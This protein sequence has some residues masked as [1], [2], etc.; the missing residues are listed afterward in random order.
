MDKLIRCNLCESK[1]YEFVYHFNK[2]IIP[3]NKEKDIYKIT[4]HSR[5]NIKNKIFRCL[6]CGLVFIHPTDE[7]CLYKKYREAQ[8]NEYLFE[9]ESKRLSARTV[10]KRIEKFVEIGKLLDIGC[11]AGFLLSEAKRRGWD[12]CGVEPSEWMVKF[13]K[14]RLHI[15]ILQGAFE[16]K[17]SPPDNFD[18]IVMLDLIE[19]LLDPKAA[20]TKVRTLLKPNGILCITTPDVDSM[21]SRLL[22]AQWWGINQFHLFYFSRNTLTMMLNLTG[23][24]ILKYR[25]H[26]RFFSLY[27]ILKLLKNYLNTNMMPSLLLHNKFLISTL[28]K[29]NLFDQIEVYAQKYG[30]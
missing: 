28:I 6:K 1:E 9:E 3:R 12:V 11:A 4:D 26:T 22:R 19:H 27:Y 18:A 13:S 30:Y 8:D 5:Q 29:L 14:E 16:E 23:F 17:D 21:M 25:W 15:D 24:K 7:N 2:D 10:L 20:L